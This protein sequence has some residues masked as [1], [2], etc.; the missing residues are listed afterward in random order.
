MSTGRPASIWKWNEMSFVVF[1]IV[2][3]SAAAAVIL[4]CV[5]GAHDIKCTKSK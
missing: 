4:L 5:H 1:H 3:F 2:V